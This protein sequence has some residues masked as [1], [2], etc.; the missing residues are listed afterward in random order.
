MII[1]T[2][3]KNIIRKMQMPDRVAEHPQE[4]KV[5]VGPNRFYRKDGSG[6]IYYDVVTLGNGTW[7]N[8]YDPFPPELNTPE[9]WTTR[10][11]SLQALAD[12]V[13]ARRGRGW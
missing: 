11:A 4:I 2:I 1:T 10:R 9:G 5:W 13:N 8:L 6:P 3:L 12:R 7:M